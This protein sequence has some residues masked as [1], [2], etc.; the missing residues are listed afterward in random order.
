MATACH[1]PGVRDCSPAVAIIV[2]A[3]RAKEL[4]EATEHRE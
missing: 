1:D 3:S 2:A 4:I